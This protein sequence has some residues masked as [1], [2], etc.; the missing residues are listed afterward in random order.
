[1]IKQ[2]QEQYFNGRFQST[3]KGYS[4]PN[5][6]NIVKAYGI[7]S[8]KISTNSKINDAFE[9][10]FASDTPLFLEVVIDSKQKVLP[11]LSVNRPV[12]D[13]DPLLSFDELKSNMFIEVLERNTGNESC[14]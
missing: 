13:Q 1:M 4:C 8:M 12:E 7:K 2:F 6:Q 3:G 5:F 9:H 14:K 10:L 11:K